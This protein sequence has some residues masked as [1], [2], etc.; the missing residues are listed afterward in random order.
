MR[1]EGETNLLDIIQHLIA[2]LGS[3]RQAFI[4]TSTNAQVDAQSRVYRSL[5][6]IHMVKAWCGKL[7]RRL[8]SDYR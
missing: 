8:R 1:P 5:H 4:L 6:L 3:S 2:R 7:V